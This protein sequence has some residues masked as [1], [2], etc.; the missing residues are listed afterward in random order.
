MVLKGSTMLPLGTVAPDFALMEPL[1]GKMVSLDDVKLEKGLLVVFMCNHC[2]FVILL[3][4][5][6]AALGTD[7][8]DMG[9]GMVGISSNDAKSYP[10]DGP[11]AMK[12]MA[13][14]TFSTF[15]YLFDETQAVAKAYR[16]ACTP[17]IFLFDGNKK[18][19]YR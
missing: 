2:P 8:K 10:Q 4:E 16:A 12:T 7:L 14:T 18:L 6:L 3:Q 13:S 9:I 1:T 11:K 19:V 17:D 5:Q 15:R